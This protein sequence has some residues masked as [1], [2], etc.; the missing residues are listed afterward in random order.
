MYLPRRG[1]LTIVCLPGLRTGQLNAPLSKS[2]QAWISQ[3]YDWSFL[4]TW[5]SLEH[6]QGKADERA[7]NAWKWYKIGLN[8]ARP[9]LRAPSSLD[10]AM[11]DETTCPINLARQSCA[12]LSIS[13]LRLRMSFTASLSTRDEQSACSM[14]LL[15]AETALYCSRTEELIFGAGWT[16]SLGFILSPCS[17][18]NLS[19]GNVPNLKPVTPPN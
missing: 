9:I 16:S 10:V 11:T 2:D 18:L 15:A 1:S 7:V 4:M 3:T 19:R 8:P 12:G 13:R 5:L 17:I 14:V 6:D